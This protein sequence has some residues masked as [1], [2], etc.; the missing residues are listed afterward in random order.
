MEIK[1]VGVARASLE[2]LLVDCQDFL[3][4]RSFRQRPKDSKE[5]LYARALGPWTNE[6]LASYALF[7]GT[8]PAETVANIARCLIHQANYLLDQQLR[9]LE[10][11]FIEEGGLRKRMTRARL[12]HC[13]GKWRPS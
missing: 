12:A 13:D 6:T 11:T 10:K 2:E 3:R 8:R 9:A 7:D 5:A 4:V 1:L